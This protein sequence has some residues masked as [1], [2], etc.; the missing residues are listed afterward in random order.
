MMVA[1]LILMGT[2]TVLIGVLPTYQSAGML[3]PVLLILLR[4]LQGFSAGGE[5]GG[6]ALMAVEHAPAD[7]RGWYGGFPQVGVPLGMLTATAVLSIVHWFSGDAFT[8]WGWRVP[9]LFSIIL[10]LVG[11]FIRLGVAESPIFEEVAK[12]DDQLRLPLI[13]MFKYNGRQLVKA[14]LTFMGNGVAGYMITGGYILPT[15]P[16]QTVWAWT[17]TMLN[18]ITLASASWIVTT[19]VAARLSDSIGRVRTYQI[20]FVLQL[21]WVFPLFML[22]DTQTWAGVIVG[23]LPLTIGLAY[24]SPQSAMFAEMFPARVR[25]SGAGLSY[26]I[27]SILRAR[28][29]R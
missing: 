18:I 6:A 15:H 4:V 20:G 23:I 3:A 24:T 12:E 19:L 28:S 21:I 14:A 13:Q 27:G 22:I 25:Y 9:F 17:K 8:V 2:A 16:V 7:K 1:T 29:L 26:A 5:W 10:I 11:M